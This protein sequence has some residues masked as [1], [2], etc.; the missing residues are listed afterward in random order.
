MNDLQLSKN[1]WLREFLRSE[2]AARMGRAIEPTPAEIANLKL[3]CENVLQPIRDALG[4]TI[5]ITSGLRPRWLNT[6]IGGS[7]TSEHIDGR[8][9]DFIIA[10]YTP[11]AAAVAISAMS[12]P[13]NQLIHEFPPNGWVHVSVAQSGERPRREIKT[14]RIVAGRTEYTSGVLAA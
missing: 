14:A 10:G 5:T 13:W 12:L 6:A 4:H 3:L 1:F 7:Q 2:T 9:A 8:A 11:Y